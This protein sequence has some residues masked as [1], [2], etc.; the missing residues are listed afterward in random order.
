MTAGSVQL[1]A[2]SQA[3]T[4]GWVSQYET[5]SLVP[6]SGSGSSQVTYSRPELLIVIWGLS[7]TTSLIV[8]QVPPPCRNGI[9]TFGFSSKSVADGAMRLT[10]MWLF[11][12]GLQTE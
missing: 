4:V 5:T 3:V 8:L 6:P 11:E 12:P 1:S 9:A 7:W 2:L 10:K